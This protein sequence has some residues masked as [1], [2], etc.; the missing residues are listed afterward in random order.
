MWRLN[1]TAELVVGAR[2]GHPV[3]ED[4]VAWPVRI[5]ECDRVVAEAEM[6]DQPL[7]DLLGVRGSAEGLYGVEGWKE[8]VSVGRKIGRLHA[9]DVK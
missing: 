6:V 5:V 2:P 9:D 4:P 3:E 1:E 7:R 8:E